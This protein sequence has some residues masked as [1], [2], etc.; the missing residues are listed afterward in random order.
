MIEKILQIFLETCLSGAKALTPRYLCLN[1][2]TTNENCEES[3]CSSYELLYYSFI[4]VKIVLVE[5][6]I[7]PNIISLPLLLRRYRS[8]EIAPK[9]SHFRSAIFA[10][11]KFR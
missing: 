4:N 10:P 9:L 3:L 11:T 6:E 1:K 8:A 5:I 7:S 2:C